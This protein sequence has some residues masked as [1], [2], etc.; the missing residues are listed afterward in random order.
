MTA[1]KLSFEDV[2]IGQ[3]VPLLSSG[4]WTSAHV[5]RW[6]A[7][8]ENWHRIHYDLP[9]AQDHD[10][11]PGLLVQGDMKPPLLFHYL[12]KWVGD[13]GWV[14]KVAVQFRG[15]DLAGETLTV[16]GRV[17]GKTSCAAFGLVTLDVGIRNTK[18]VD[19]TRGTAVIALPF[20]AGAPV[21]YP[22][23]PPIEAGRS[24]S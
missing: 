21:P 3:D 22:F 11:L 20:A 9:F 14:W 7:A 24:Q 4:P 6:S 13:S 2:E 1:H 8:T 19:A 18:G 23:S 12:T 17:T 10:K 15:M 16:W 5:M